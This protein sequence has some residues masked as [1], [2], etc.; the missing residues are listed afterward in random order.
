MRAENSQNFSGMKI[1]QSPFLFNVGQFVRV[2]KAGYIPICL[3]A[4]QTI[5]GTECL[6]F[7]NPVTVSPPFLSGVILRPGQSIGS[8]GVPKNIKMMGKSVEGSPIGL[9][10]AQSCSSIISFVLP[11]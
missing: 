4:S 10:K 5:P 11:V 9:E 7:S 1:S 3:K 2:P 8:L 6:S